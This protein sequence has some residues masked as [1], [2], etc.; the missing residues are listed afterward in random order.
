MI[1]IRP[2][3]AYNVINY[4]VNACQSRVVPALGDIMARLTLSFLGPF[5]V[6][7]D[8]QP[9]LGFESNKVR[10]LLVYLAVEAD[11]SHTREALAGLL[12]PDYPERSAHN[13]LR[14]ALANLR[15]AIG[16]RTA[17][18][19]FLLISRETIRFNPDC[20]HMLD[21]AG[22][23]NL[24]DQSPEQMADLATAWRGEFF[25]GF[26]LPDSPPFEE[27]LVV[28]RAHFNQQ[29]MALLG[30]LAAQLEAEGHTDQAID[31]T[32]RQ[33]TLEAWDEAAHRRLMRLLAISGRRDLALAQYEACRRQLRS[34]LGV[35]PTRETEA[36]Y[37]Q[38]R[39]QTFALLAGPRVPEPPAPG[40]PPYKGL[41]YFE[42]SDADRFFGR[43]ALTAVLV[44]H[45]VE[46]L[47]A[48]HDSARVLTVIGASGSGKSSIV[49]AGLV[50][51]L[52]QLDL[53][54]PA[55]AT[56]YRP[57][58][59]GILLM[60]PTACPLET[61]AVSLTA[62]ADSVM[63]TAALIDDL[64]RNPR[65]L[66]LAAMK[67]TGSH[68]AER[69]LLVV[70]QFEELFSLCRDEAARR[71]F[72]DNL[73][74]AAR[75]AGPVVVVIALRAD[76][77]A[78]CAP[79]DNLRRALTDRQV[80]IGAMSD[81][82]LRWAIE[83]PA[84][85]G[86]W[87]FEP[88][89]ADIFLREVGDSP[90]ALPLLSHALLETWRRR[91][92]RMMTLAGYQAS[93]GVTGA[94]TRTAE[95]I[96]RE[97]TPREQAIARNV[98]VRLT[99]FDESA[100]QGLPEFYTRRR[101]S[102]AELALRPEDASQVHS[103]LTRLANARLIT[104]GQETAEVTHEALI[105]E[106]SRLGEWLSD[107]REGLRLHRQLTQAAQE[108]ERSARDPSLLYRGAR[109]AQ[110][111]EWAAG[112]VD[113]LNDLEREFLAAARSEEMARQQREL[114]AAQELAEA[115]RRRAEAESLR[116]EEQAQAVAKLR[117]RAISLSL[118]LGALAALFL[119]AVWLGQTAN[120]NAQEREAQARLAT[121]RELAAA[122]ISSL[123]ADPERGVLLALEAL[124]MADTL[125]AR[126]ALH[127]S[128]PELHVQ[129]IIP[130]HNALGTPGV[131]FSP[132]G[133]RLA[134]IG[135]REDGFVRIWDTATGE[136]LM[137][138]QDVPGDFGSSIDYSPDGELLA[139]AWGTL[140]PKVIVWNAETG[141]KVYKWTGEVLGD[142]DRL[143]F[144]PDGKMLAVANLSGVPTVFDL[145]TGDVAFTLPGHTTVIEAIAFSP[146]SLLLATGDDDGVVKIWDVAMQEELVT[147]THNGK[148]HAVAFSP[149]G[150]RLATAGEDGKLTIWDIP[151]ERVLLSLPTR[152]GLYD[153]AFMPDGE[154]VVGTHQEG[155]TTVW[156]ATSGQ[157][158][159]NLAGHGSTVIS[160]SVAPDNHTIATGGYDGTVRIW[161]ISPGR[162]ILSVAAHQ[163][164]VNKVAY[165]PHSEQVLTVS[166]DG[167][168]TLWEA[169]TGAFVRQLLA[170]DSARLDSVAFNPD[171]DVAA[172]GDSSGNIRIVEV[173][174]GAVTQ[175]IDAHDGEVWDVAFSPDG[176]RLAS[177][178]WDFT[179]KVWAVAGGR[180][181]STLAAPC[182][183][184]SVVWS[185]DGGHLFSSCGTS[186]M[187]EGENAEPV[188]AYEWDAATGAIVQGFPSGGIDLYGLA[189]SPD[190]C[191]V[192][193]SFA[194][195]D[196]ALHD[197]SSGEKLRQL[198]GHAGIA[199]GMAFSPDGRYLA[200]SAFDQLAKIWDVPTGQELATFYGNGNN[201]FEVIFSPDG[202]RLITAGGDGTVRVFTPDMTE[203]VE[204]ARSRVTRSLT[205]AECRKYLHLDTCPAAGG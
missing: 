88:G 173:A 27:W 137:E 145:T 81:E 103:V 37:E 7:L 160:V 23:R 144:S 108:W 102:L 42:E 172:I 176:A 4:W 73:L 8:G 154:R 191:T 31:I 2:V 34:E 11:R 22:F 151:G 136:K 80:Y 164:P 199:Y 32:K 185:P 57:F 115:E 70:D 193:L 46:C 26:N 182:W 140:D 78:Q 138:L 87:T 112:H 157:Q 47:K 105:R 170:D 162:E 110:T 200:T 77:Y 79:Y 71:A 118:A 116:A 45:I 147:F 43:E 139:S 94:L 114:Q 29:M 14:S 55:R 111:G 9:A 133:T 142:V 150:A 30:R 194:N 62:T 148:I 61:L 52:R 1:E 183:A 123:S 155:A 35:A 106:W 93:G 107:N 122:A 59:E 166:G 75:S 124:E 152:S 19:P 197:V 204:L 141:E 95:S 12:W 119:L 44:N 203:L 65:S 161:D 174:T 91:E 92:G 187:P 86:E 158:L 180:A 84:E 98:F 28:Q 3:N 177:A 64:A 149:E 189:L 5:R 17:D 165:H 6:T 85:Q 202:T 121:S 128:L 109:L 130:A 72:I 131:A 50:P 117:R 129:R 125:E 25:E 192:A 74:T 171:G 97:F 13:N 175:T 49:R 82:E 96:Y 51:A 60:T 179:S 36:L 76:F 24:D 134:S 68:P 53:P 67:L 178:S 201:I 156:D 135:L 188:A 184:M 101:A 104:T 20:D 16:D 21:V 168:A 15:G 190:G 163:G 146:D 63:T 83:A 153:V 132:D 195:G 69:L 54:D 159:L 58:G 205:E 198:S 10:A 167:T 38:I 169:T 40:K 196:V 33:L 90:G 48:N 66:H 89:L 41:S 99:E 181:V 120:R 56:T 39:D 18:P 126:N 186:T 100:D 127:Q 143:D 113:D